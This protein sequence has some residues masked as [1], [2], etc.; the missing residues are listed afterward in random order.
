LLLSG[1]ALLVFA[2]M[3]ARAGR[4][5]P[6]P[7][8]AVASALAGFRGWLGLYSFGVVLTPPV[9]AW[10]LWLGA[11]AW[12][13]IAWSRATSFGGA[14]YHP[15]HAPAM[16]FELLGLLALLVASLQLLSLYLARRSSYPRLAVAFYV[17]WFAYEAVDMLFASALPGHAP[18]GEALA[19]L[20]KFAVAASI[21]SAYLLSS[22]RVAATVRS[23]VHAPPAMPSAEELAGM[24]QA[25]PTLAKRFAEPA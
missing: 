15:L 19:Q 18:Q 2:R 9:L 12:G 5:D 1:L 10:Q 24:P 6:A 8:A 4:Y 20:A 25:A 7:A 16:L 22:R 14:D 17:L 11:D 13:N 21:W 3:A 23:R